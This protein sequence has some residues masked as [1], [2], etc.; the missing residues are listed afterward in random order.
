MTTTERNKRDHPGPIAR[1]NGD[2]DLAGSQL[3]W[4]LPIAAAIL[5]SVLYVDRPVSRFSERMF[6]HFGWAVTFTDTPSFFHPFALLLFAVFLL[7]R[8][9]RRQFENLD[10]ACLLGDASVLLSDFITDKLKYFFGRTWPKY[11]HPSFIH[12]DVY[13]FNLLHSGASYQSF[14]SGHVAA[15]CAVLLV[16]WIFYP[17]FRGL[18]ALTVI[19]FSAALVAMNYHFLSDAIAG[20][21]VGMLTGWLCVFGW[22]RWNAGV[23]SRA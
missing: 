8:F 21:L 20:G 13:G 14:P 7:R 18:Y 9:M 11:G 3:W 17:R 12:Q 16:F 23:K 6:G 4:I 10:V 22:Q 5:F 19:G 15:L 2:R 1:S